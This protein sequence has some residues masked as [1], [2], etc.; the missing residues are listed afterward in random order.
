MVKGQVQRSSLVKYVA[1]GGINVSQTP[2][3][4]SLVNEVQYEL[5]LEY[6]VMRAWF[7]SEVKLNRRL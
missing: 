4:Y 5:E 3:V 6:A 2:F 1:E 7:V